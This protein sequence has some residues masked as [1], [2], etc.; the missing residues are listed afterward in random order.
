[1]LPGLIPLLVFVLADEFAGTTYAVILALI[2]GVVIFA[3]TWIRHK[4]PD[5]FV[6]FDTLLLALFGG[7]SLVLHDAI[8]FKLKP[9]IIQTILVIIIGI[10]AFSPKNIIL[11]MARH[12]MP[13]QEFGEAQLVQ[14]QRQTKILF[15]IF[16]VHTLLVFYSAFYMSKEAWAFISGGLFYIV[17]GI[18]LVVELIRQKLLMAR[19]EWVPVLNADGQVTGKATREQV[20]SNRKILHPVVHL[21]VFNEKGDLYI[22]KKPQNKIIQPGKWDTAIGGHVAFKETPQ[23]AL[24]REAKEELNLSPV[25]AD[26]L[27]SY[28]W[29]SP[30]EKEFVYVF[31]LKTHQT[32]EPNPKEVA[33]GKFMKLKE[34]KKNL[35]KSFFTPNFEKEFSL[36]LKTLSKDA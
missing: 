18:W 3:L 24:A 16:A 4:K 33:D 6:L 23:K 29:E 34:I 20:H 32:P 22:Q 25:N 7:I 21:H 13:S 8:F 36:L 14:M 2:S 28:I 26:F 15:W 12:Y 1:M 30:V 27:F 35:G 10:S 9:A 11:T 31:A 5:K 17:A 19:K